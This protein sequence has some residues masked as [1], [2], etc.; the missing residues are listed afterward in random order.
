M[1]ESYI[2]SHMDDIEKYS[3][4]MENRAEDILDVER[5]VNCSREFREDCLKTDTFYIEIDGDYDTDSLLDAVESVIE[6]SD[7]DERGILI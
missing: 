1:S 5:L 3:R 4:Q 6:D 7:P 2:R